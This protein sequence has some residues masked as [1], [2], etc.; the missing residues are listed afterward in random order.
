MAIR[1]FFVLG[2]ATVVECR[3]VPGTSQHLGHGTGDTLVVNL[4]RCGKAFPVA[5]GLVGTRVAAGKQIGEARAIVAEETLQTFRNLIAESGLGGVTQDGFGAVV[6]AHDDEAFG[7]HRE[8]V[9]TGL[10]LLGVSC[11]GELGHICLDFGIGLHK[12]YAQRFSR[13][14]VNGFSLQAADK[15]RDKQG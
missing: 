15:Q 10:T 14:N 9:E 2:A 4:A 13:L 12:L 6:G 3:L 11:V 8:D 5:D 7:L 1:A